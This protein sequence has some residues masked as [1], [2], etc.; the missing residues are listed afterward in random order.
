MWAYH[1]SRDSRYRIPFGAAPAGGTVTLGLSTGGD[2]GAHVALR[3]WVDGE[4]EAFV[5]MTGEPEGDHLRF[6]CE[7]TRESPAIVWYSF[8]IER[9][10]GRVLRL[11]L[12]HI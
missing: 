5:P 8:V 2:S 7:F 1:D 10:D 11:S 4:G 3:T 6:S 9:S 12:I